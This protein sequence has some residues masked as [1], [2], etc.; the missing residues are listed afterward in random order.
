MRR[1][2]KLVTS[3]RCICRLA[4]SDDIRNPSGIHRSAPD[5]SDCIPTRNG[6]AF[7]RP[8]FARR[9]Y[10][11]PSRPCT[12]PPGMGKPPNTMVSRNHPECFEFAREPRAP[13][14]VLSA[15]FRTAS[16]ASSA[17]SAVADPAPQS[18][19]ET[20]AR[21]PSLP[22]SSLVSSPS[23]HRRILAPIAPRRVHSAWSSCNRHR[24]GPPRIEPR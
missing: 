6:L 17:V 3:D 4:R 13:R 8:A 11:A 22:Q 10:P 20:N 5:L 2:G 19:R 7:P 9:T 24:R 12:C 16:C 21:I 1:R 14:T 23:R 15:G 18:C